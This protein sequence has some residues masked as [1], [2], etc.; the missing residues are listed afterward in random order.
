MKQR[1]FPRPGFCCPVGSSGTTAAS[2]AHPARPPFPGLRLSAGDPP[3]LSA[4]T[5]PGRA[6]PVPIATFRAFHTPCAGEFFGAAIQ[7]LRPFRGLR[8][9]QL[10]SALP[11]SRLSASTPT[12][13]QALLDAADRSVAPPCRALDAGLRPDPFP[14]RAAGL[15]PASWQLPGRDSHPLAATSLCWIVGYPF[16][17]SRL[18]GSPIHKPESTTRAPSASGRRGFEP[19][20][21]ASTTWSGCAAG[22]VRLPALR[23]RRRLAALPT[24]ASSAR[25]ARIAPR[26]RRGRSSIAPALPSLSGSPPAGCSP[27]KRTGSRRSR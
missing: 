26:S 3:A 19:T 21:T 10:G 5:G 11:L 17:R 1:P 9:G 16:N 25:P 18:G 23:Q 8:R 14:D 24:A 2:D 15:L 6:S 27:L 12:T 22:G 13:R 7:G 20:P 4:A